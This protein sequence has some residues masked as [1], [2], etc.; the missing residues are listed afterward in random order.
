MLRT[1]NSVLTCNMM[2]SQQI[3]YGGRPPYWKSSF[4]YISAIYCQVFAK[5]CVK[6]QNQVQTQVTWPKYQILT[7]K[8]GGRPPSLK[9]VLSLY[10]TRESSDFDEIW[11]TDWKNFASKNGHV[12]IY[13]KIDEVQNGGQPSYWKL[14]FG[15]ISTSYCPIDAIFGMYK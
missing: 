15:Y 6:K 7:I 2:T 1:W 5:F 10:L 14:S 9:M 12:L 4:G 13:K 3:Q 8:D 11:W